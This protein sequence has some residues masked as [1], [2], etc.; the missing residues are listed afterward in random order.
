MDAKT[1]DLLINAALKIAVDA[2][3]LFPVAGQVKAGLEIARDA[4]P[5]IEAAY[6]YF[7]TPEG[8]R[9][10]SH[11]RAVFGALQTTS[12]EPVD[13]SVA[14]AIDALEKGEA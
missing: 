13:W 5:V 3:G 14:K 11:V 6:D 7:Q 8:Q 10:I 2:T 9:A 4:A 12:G 1:R